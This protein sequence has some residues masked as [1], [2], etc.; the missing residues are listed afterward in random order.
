MQWEAWGEVTTTKQNGAGVEE[1]CITIA[2]LEPT[3]GNESTNCGPPRTP[4]FGEIARTPYGVVAASM[5][6]PRAKHAVIRIKGGRALDLRLKPI[7][8]RAGVGRPTWFY[9]YFARGF[10]SETCITRITAFDARGRIVTREPG[11]GRCL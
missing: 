6:A 3:E 10:R 4:P 2:I 9:S 1:A 8:L 5:F 11:G 7:R